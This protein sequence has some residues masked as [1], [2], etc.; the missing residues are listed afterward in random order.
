MRSSTG[1]KLAAMV[2]A[3]GLTA[4]ALLSL[5]QSRFQAAH[6]LARSQERLRRHEDEVLKLRAQAL[7][8]FGAEL[9]RAS[10]DAGTAAPAGVVVDLVDA[11]AG[12]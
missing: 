11:E 3:V 8:A 12:E 5:R 2:V 4:C 10:G 1:W 7:A 9:E 6:E